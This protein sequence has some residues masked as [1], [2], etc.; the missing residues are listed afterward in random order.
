MSRIEKLYQLGNSIFSINDLRIIW[1]EQNPDAL[2]SSVKYYVDAGKL[3]RLRR[4]IFAL[5]KDFNTFELA[6]KLITPSYISLETALQKHGVTFQFSSVVTSLA[7]YSRR[8]DIG[9]QTYAYHSIQLDILLN[10]LGILHEDHHTI[11]SSERAVCDYIYL[12]GPSHF[13]NLRTLDHALMRVIAK[14]YANKSVENSIIRLMK[15]L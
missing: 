4:G 14:I 13:D 7:S 10:P 2:K 1:A 5:S 15:N 8:I 11:A 9:A 12:H 3:Q 6:N